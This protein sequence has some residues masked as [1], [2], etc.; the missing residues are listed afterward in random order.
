[1]FLNKFDSFLIAPEDYLLVQIKLLTSS[2]YRKSISKRSLQLVSA[3][4]EQLYEAVVDPKNAYN[5]QDQVDLLLHLQK[6]GF[7][8]CVCVWFNIKKMK[9]NIWSNKAGNTKYNG[10]E[11]IPS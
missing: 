6:L 11:E 10:N 9:G 8:V 1:M 7:C 4:Y 3:T 2:A 5:N